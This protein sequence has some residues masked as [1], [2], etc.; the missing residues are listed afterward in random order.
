MKKIVISI[1]IFSIFLSCGRNKTPEPERETGSNVLYNRFQSDEKGNFFI[2]KEGGV[3]LL[4]NSNI[5]KLN[6][7]ELP[8]TPKTEFITGNKDTIMI[9]QNGTLKLTVNNKGLVE[10]IGTISG[11]KN[12]DKIEKKKGLLFVIT[13]NSDCNFGTREAA[14]KVFNLSEPNKIVQI[15]TAKLSDPKDLLFD[16]NLIFVAEGKGG[17]VILE[18]DSNG[19]LKLLSRIESKTINSLS[20]NPK[21]KIIIGK[22]NSEVIQFDYTNSA[23]PKILST[24]NLT[25]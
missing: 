21:K 3:K 17:F 14:L 23:T 10:E 9:N 2:L 18:H 19:I 16:N 5:E 6:F 8:F 24:I 12:C 25:K 20:L 13:G 22:N 4:S 15:T 7:T 11:F 1:S